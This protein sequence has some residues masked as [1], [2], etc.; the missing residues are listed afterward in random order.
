[1]QFAAFLYSCLSCRFMS[2]LWVSYLPILKTLQ[3]SGVIGYHSVIFKVLLSWTACNA[4]YK[5]FTVLH[6]KWKGGGSATARHIQRGF[7]LTQA[8]IKEG[9][10]KGGYKGRGKGEVSRWIVQSWKF[11]SFPQKHCDCTIVHT[12]WY[13]TPSAY[14]TAVFK[15]ICRSKEGRHVCDM[16]ILGLI[17]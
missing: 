13:N 15:V 2:E 12:L 4:T 5:P 6:W 11:P 16:F 17:G 14:W 8:A 7:I 10:R 3:I 9:G 1:M